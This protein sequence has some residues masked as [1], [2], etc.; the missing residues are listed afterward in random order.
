MKFGVC[1]FGKMPNVGPKDR[2]R[3]QRIKIGALAMDVLLGILEIASTATLNGTMII[4]EVSITF[5]LVDNI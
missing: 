2:E 3:W 1:K 5:F 4:N